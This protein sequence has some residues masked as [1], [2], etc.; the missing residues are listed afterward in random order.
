MRLYPT[1]AQERALVEMLRVTRELY[2]ALLQQRRDAWTTRRV[3]I[4]SKQQYAG[5]RRFARQ[6]RPGLPP[7]IV[8]VWMPRCDDRTSRLRRSFGGLRRVKSRATRA[9]SLHAAG[10]SSSFRTAIRALRWNR[11]QRG[12]FIPGVGG[13]RVAQGPR[14][15]GVWGGVHRDKERPLV[16]DIRGAPR[17]RSTPAS[18]QRV[19]I[20][21]GRRVL[22]ALSDGTS[23]PEPASRLDSRCPH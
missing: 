17:R 2:N 20:D 11:G 14:G 19:G 16:R 23:D 8:N 3:S 12:V 4:T 5:N 6:R 15:P 18:S 22:A 21:R 9:L 7:S 1:C 13:V 10:I